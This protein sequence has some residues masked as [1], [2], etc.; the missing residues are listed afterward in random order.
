MKRHN[1]QP[2]SEVLRLWTN[3]HNRKPMFLQKKL[4]ASWEVWFGKLIAKNTM[5]LSIRG[6]KL[7][8]NVKSGPVKYEMNLNREKIMQTIHEQIHENYFD[9][10]IIS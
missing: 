8:V 2:I 10:I 7:Y 4:E 1:D 9:E 3:A 6:T 5:K